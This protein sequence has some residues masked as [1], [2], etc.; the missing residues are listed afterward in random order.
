M[1]VKAYELKQEVQI[2]ERDKK[3]REKRAKI[4]NNEFVSNVGQPT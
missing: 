4:D 1:E 2:A 3:E